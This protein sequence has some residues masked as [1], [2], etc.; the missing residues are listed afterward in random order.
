MSP[1]TRPTTGVG[2]VDSGLAAAAEPRPETREAA[3]DVD[4]SVFRSSI[5][6][7]SAVKNE[8]VKATKDFLHQRPPRPRLCSKLLATL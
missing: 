8:E 6:I 7:R 2:G 3:S 4:G 5:K 1:R